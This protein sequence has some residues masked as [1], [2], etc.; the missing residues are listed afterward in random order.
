VATAIADLEQTQDDQVAASGR[1]IVAKK[2]P[3]T[4][5]MDKFLKKHS[6]AK[7]LANSMVQR[8][9]DLD[10]MAYIATTNLP[11]SHVETKGFR[12]YFCLCN[13]FRSRSQIFEF[14]WKYSN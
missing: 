13:N 4:G 14:S 2:R 12:R 10:L 6:P 3:I 5:T 11:F 9:I 7:Y 1:G 8:P